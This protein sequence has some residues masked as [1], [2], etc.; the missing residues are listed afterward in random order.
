MFLFRWPKYI[1]SAICKNRLTESYTNLK[2]LFH[3]TFNTDIQRLIHPTRM[4]RFQKGYFLLFILLFITEVLIALF[5]HDRFI[6]PYFGDFLVVILIYCFCRTFRPFPVTWLAIS[7]LIFAYFIEMLQYF[8]ITN[9]LHLQDSKL[10]TTILG[11]SF[12]WTDILAYTL[13]IILV[14]AIEK[15]RHKK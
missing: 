8:K 15:F 12:E 2:I 13:G 11:S 1:G 3:I 6:R 14:V 5:L 4:L 10:A 7:V 9:W